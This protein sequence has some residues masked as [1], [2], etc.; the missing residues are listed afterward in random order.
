MAQWKYKVNIKNIWN[1][2]TLSLAEKGVK[3]AKVIKRTFPDEWLDFYHENYNEELES[4][5]EGFKNITGY[6][7]TPPVEEFDDYMHRLYDF[8]DMNVAPFG[9]VRPKNTRYKMAWIKTTF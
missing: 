3:I 1:N 9:M 2:D 5:V 8:G 7:N 6:D 4:I